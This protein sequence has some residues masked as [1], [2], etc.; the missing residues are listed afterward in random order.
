ML[1]AWHPRRNPAPPPELLLAAACARARRQGTRRSWGMRAGCAYMCA[2][3]KG[4]MHAGRRSTYV[5]MPQGVLN[6]KGPWMHDRK[7]C[8][9]NRDGRWRLLLH[10]TPAFSAPPSTLCVCA[11]TSIHTQ[12]RT[13]THIDVP[14]VSLNVP[15]SVQPSVCQCACSCVRPAASKGCAHRAHHWAPHTC[16]HR[17]AVARS[18]STAA[19]HNTVVRHSGA[20]ASRAPAGTSA[21]VW[22]G[23]GG[24]T[25]AGAGAGA[26]R[27]ASSARAVMR[28]GWWKCSAAVP[29]ARLH[30]PC[31]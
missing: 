26:R 5:R 1:G 31:A 19:A 29:N 11:C 6:S 21:W 7:R 18:S 3:F 15:L 17:P 28:P 4:R 12:P 22:P 20:C 10:W 2:G 13:R 9:V 24:C 25:G 23:L 14:C 8:C 30:R 27:R 16:T